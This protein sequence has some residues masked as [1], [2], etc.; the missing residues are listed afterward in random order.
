MAAQ[1]IGVLVDKLADKFGVAVEKLQPLAE[2]VVRQYV[3]RS[4]L[5]AFS[6]FGGCVILMI[7]GIWFWRAAC[8]TKM[9]DDRVQTV[10]LSALMVAA[11]L[12]CFCIGIEYVCHA[13]APLPSIL[14]L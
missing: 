11:S 1:E 5:C 7:C 13:V 8:A 10:C 6:V 12:I 4:W 14:G 2:E 3:V 9:E